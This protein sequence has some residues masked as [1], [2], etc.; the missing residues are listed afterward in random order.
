MINKEDYLYAKYNFNKPV[1]FVE[2]VGVDI[3][4]I[5]N[6]ISKV[7]IKTFN[8]GSINIGVIGAYKKN[9]GWNDIIKLDNL[10]KD[11]KNKFF[12]LWLWKL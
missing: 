6:E 5:K 7:K 10:L 4:R 3:D 1:Y 12:V 11:K 8:H 2:G 9:K